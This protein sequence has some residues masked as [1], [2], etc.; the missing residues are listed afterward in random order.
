MSAIILAICPKLALATEVQP[1]FIELAQNVT[2]ADYFKGNYN[3]AVALRASHMYT[4]SQRNLGEGGAITN[5]SEGKLSIGFSSSKAEITAM[6]DDLNQTGYGRQ[7]KALIA[8]QFPAIG[9]LGQNDPVDTA[10]LP[11]DPYS[12]NQ[13]LIPN[14]KI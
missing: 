6:D 1:I 13:G 9:V 11:I 4:L 7:L 8:G 14:V 2:S 3:M 10:S 5:K 12:N